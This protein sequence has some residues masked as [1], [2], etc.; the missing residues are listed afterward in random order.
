MSL[1]SPLTYALIAAT[2]NALLAIGVKESTPSI[3]PFVFIFYS[4][5]FCTFFSF[6]ASLCIE[7]PEY[8]TNL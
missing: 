4:T 3:S 7:N 6:G 8:I 1:H 2:G 5:L